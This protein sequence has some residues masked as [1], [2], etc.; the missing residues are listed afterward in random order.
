VREQENVTAEDTG[1]ITMRSGLASRVRKMCAAGG[2]IAIFAGILAA[3][4]G[5]QLA[6][7]GSSMLPSDIGELKKIMLTPLRW[8]CYLLLLPA[9][10]GITSGALGIAAGLKFPKNAK[11]AAKLLF[12][13]AALSLPDFFVAISLISTA[14]F[15]MARR[16]IRRGKEDE[17]AY[18]PPDE[19]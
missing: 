4:A 15:I 17:A 6:W 2:I 8:D 14:L 16:D 7:F 1:V 19:Y 13:A 9:A 18:Q 3:S 5:L 12:A 11:G 10:S